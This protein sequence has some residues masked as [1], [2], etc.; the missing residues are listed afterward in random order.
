[1]VTQVRHFIL[2]RGKSCE[3]GKPHDKALHSRAAWYTL[4]RM[5]ARGHSFIAKERIH[6]IH[7][8]VEVN[9]NFRLL[10]FAYAQSGSYLENTRY[11]RE[12]GERW[13]ERFSSRASP[14]FSHCQ[15]QVKCIT[16]VSV[17]KLASGYL[18]RLP[19]PCL[20]QIGDCG[21]IAVLH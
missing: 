13:S 10:G 1:M 11:Y 4:L 15:C 20:V 18:T 12:D 16:N 9:I 21:R 3:H 5:K 17:C 2:Q 8:Q 7:P 14:Y 19:L 6:G